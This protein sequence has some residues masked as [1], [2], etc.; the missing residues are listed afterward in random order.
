MRERV[1]RGDPPHPARVVSRPPGVQPLHVR[2]RDAHPLLLRVPGHLV[3]RVAQYR[4]VDLV[5]EVELVQVVRVVH[6]AQGALGAAGA[7][8]LLRRAV[9][10]IDQRG[11]AGDHVG[12]GLLHDGLGVVEGQPPLSPPPRLLPLEPPVELQVLAI[13][14]QAREVHPGELLRR[15]PRPCR[16][17][18]RSCALHRIDHWVSLSAPPRPRGRGAA[19]GVGTYWKTS[20]TAALVTST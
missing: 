18:P 9:Q 17:Q 15:G 16:G 1:A 3:R 20:H 14:P 4:A 13:R 7:L 10:R 8:Q 6:L 19:Q 2:R 5:V 12:R 11:V